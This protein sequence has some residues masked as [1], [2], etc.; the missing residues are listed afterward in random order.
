MKPFFCIL[1]FLLWLPAVA[2][3]QQD[4]AKSPSMAVNAGFFM[5]GGASLGADV[6][7]LFAK[8]RWSVQAGAGLLSFGAGVSYHLKPRINSPFVS[9]QYWHQI[10]GKENFDI[11]GVMYVYRYKKWFQAGAGLGTF[12]SES[13]EQKRGEVLPMFQAGIFVPVSPASVKSKLSAKL[14]AI[15]NREKE[16]TRP[17]FQQAVYFELFGRTPLLYS[18]NYDCHF[19]VGKS[20]LGASVGMGYIGIF[21]VTAAMVPVSL[22]YLTGSGRSHLELGIGATAQ[23]SLPTSGAVWWT[24][25][26]ATIGY[27]YQPAEGFLLRIGL[28]PMYTI[29]SFGLT[30]GISLGYAF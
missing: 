9:L 23:G 17:R 28:T 24:V 2:L 27:R 5:G 12:L 15:K 21:G 20:G 22:Y 13:G 10:G 16:E 25:G 14:Q 7:Y 26:T 6:E 18:V 30:G 19:V 8:N 29:S 4:S 11:L 3:G 1:L